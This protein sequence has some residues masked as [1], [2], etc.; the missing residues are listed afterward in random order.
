VDSIQSVNRPTILVMWGDHLPALQ[1]Q[2]Y[3]QS[4]GGM[5]PEQQQRFLHETTLLVA[6]NFPLQEKNIG[7]VAPSFFGPLVFSLTGQQLPPYY[8][9]LQSVEKE[10]PGVSPNVY[11]DSNGTPTLQ[12]NDSQ[13]NL[14]HDYEMVQYDLLYGKGYAQSMF[15]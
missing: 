12:L 1:Q 8:Q 11:V 13:K 4:L 2:T 7:T 15:Q 6:A 5:T 3:D 10:L 14:L 9:L